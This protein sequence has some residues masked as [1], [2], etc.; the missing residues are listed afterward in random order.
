MKSRDELRD[1]YERYMRLLKG[2]AD[3]LG[4]YYVAVDLVGK[5]TAIGFGKAG[6]IRIPSALLA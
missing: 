4:P 6:R 1:I 3:S 2:P 5:N